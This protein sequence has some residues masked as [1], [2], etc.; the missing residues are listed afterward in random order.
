MPI[1][2]EHPHRFPRQLV[3]AAI[4]PF[5][6]TFFPTETYRP[7]QPTRPT[8]HITSCCNHDIHITF[9]ALVRESRGAHRPGMQLLH[10][11]W[12]GGDPTSRP[13][14]LPC[15]SYPQIWL[16]CEEQKQTLVSKTSS[17]EKHCKY[18]HSSQLH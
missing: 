1:E 5:A 4:P 12:A 16:H 2:R 18:V 10:Q 3:D 6:Q 11:R 13:S 14:H 9:Y 17:R 7:R 8:R 15:G